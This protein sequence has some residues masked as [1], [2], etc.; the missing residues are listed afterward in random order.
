MAKY[1]V[2]CHLCVITKASYLKASGLLQPLPLHHPSRSDVPLEYITLLPTR[3]GQDYKHI[4]FMVYRPDE[5]VPLYPGENNQGKI[6][7]KCL[8]RQALLATQDP[9]IFSLR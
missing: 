3:H 7:Y 2:N 4:S 5:N 1:I 6:A 8:C 9:G